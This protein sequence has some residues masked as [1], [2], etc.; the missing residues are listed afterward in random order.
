M[1]RTAT[2]LTL[3]GALAG[4][5]RGAEQPRTAALKPDQQVVHAVLETLAADG[6][7]VCVER[8]TFGS[9][10]SIYRIATQG[11]LQ[12]NYALAWYPP[13]PFRPPHMPTLRE[14]RSAAKEGRNAE[15]PEPEARDDALPAEQ[16]ARFDRAALALAPP[17]VPTHRV[18]ISKKWVPEGVIPRWL[19]VADRKKGCA[20]QYVVSGV[21]MAPDIAFAAVRV[22]HWGTVYALE[23]SPRGWKPVAQWGSWLY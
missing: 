15:M 22:D 23:P 6:K 9:P 2:I 1:R 11:R 19:P 13:K 16:Q 18:G 14:L 7:P 4:C 8:E 21:K 5:S 3:L 12:N 17:K 10:L 20:A